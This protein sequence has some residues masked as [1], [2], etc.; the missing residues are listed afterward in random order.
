M[1]WQTRVDDWQEREGKG[2]DDIDPG[3][4]FEQIARVLKGGIL[5]RVMGP[6]LSSLGTEG[7]REQVANSASSMNEQQRTGL[8]KIL[9]GGLGSRGIDLGSILKRLG[10]DPSVAE[11]PGE[12]NA[13]DLAKLAAHAHQHDHGLFNKAMEFYTEYPLLIQTLGAIAI[14]AII[15]YLT[16]EE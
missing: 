2:I 5:R 9:L 12:A 11:N 7:V 1:D 15:T 16:Q 3:R 6:A 8:A 14:A 4:L 10:I 13:E